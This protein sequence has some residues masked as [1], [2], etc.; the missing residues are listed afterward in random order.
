M[1]SS[2]RLGGF[3]VLKGMA[4]FSLVLPETSKY[5]PAQFCYQLARKNINLPYIT[6]MHYDGIWGMNLMVDNVHGLRVSLL[7]EENIGKTFKYSSESVIL[8]VF[9]HKSNPEIT[10]KLLEIFGLKNIRPG[11]LANS[12]SAISVVLD[13]TQLS[14]ASEALFEPFSF[15]AYRTPADWK[16]AQKGKEEIYKE[17]IA[18]Y[19]EQ[20]PKVYALECYDGQELLQVSINSKNMSSIG[21]L[22]IEFAQSGLALT[23]SATGPSEQGELLDF[24]L[25]SSEGHSHKEVIKR[26]APE[27]YMDSNPSAA[28]F[29]MNGPHFGDRYGIASELLA[30]FKENKIDLLCLSCT[31]ASISGVV[32]SSQLEATIST[33]EQCFEVPAVIRK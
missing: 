11:A 31:I 13:E 27:A 26:L 30:A 29:S 21:E 23:F 8:S 12:P 28:V 20:K 4:G 10:G 5:S 15:S 2:T 18:S 17:V 33:L 22:L 16:L 19:Q 6:C 14:S 1:T 7:I 32:P 24:C 25:P 3:K 9:P